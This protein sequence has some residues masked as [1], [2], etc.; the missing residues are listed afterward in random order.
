MTV[1]MI[2]CSLPAFQVMQRLE[3]KWKAL[4]ED[5]IFICKVKCS[6]LPDISEKESLKDCVE[7]WFGTKDKR[8]D[9]IVFFCAA[10]IAVRTIAPFLRH[11][12]LDPAVLVVDEQGKFCIS[13]LSGHAGGANELTERIA[14]MLRALPVI[15]T[16]TDV[17][18]KFAVDDFA[19]RNGLVVTDWDMAKK[20]SVNILNG[21][22]VGICS[23]IPLANETPE[24]ICEGD[25][26]KSVGILISYRNILSFPFQRTLQLVPRT[27][28]LG[29][30]C[31]KN[32]SEEKI[33]AA[34]DSCLTE[35]NI[36]YESI[37]AAASIDLK[38]HEQGLI[39]WC[40]KMEIPFFTYTAEELRRVCGRFTDSAFVEQVTGVSNVCE[41]S[42]I[43]AAGNGEL[44]VGK[45]IYDG[46][47]VAVAVKKG[48]I[49][50]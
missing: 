23:D 8:A 17:E 44:L 50:F 6:S 20:V 19:R 9:A 27:L 32:T 48:S 4:Q 24:G 38:M 35:E 36:R 12:S 34:V 37:F 10:G 11:K 28:A 47:T 25:L 49:S 29:I 31:R 22:R 2:A 5:V 40:N 1:L 15:T 14:G 46:V 39:E 45:R 33:R 21:A 30:G 43:L 7:E 26:E 16:A 42:A 41:R 13:L 18:G 3:R